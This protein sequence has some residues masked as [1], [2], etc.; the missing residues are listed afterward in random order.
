MLWLVSMW[1]AW[2][3]LAASG[4]APF[5]DFPGIDEV[6]NRIDL[7]GIALPVILIVGS[8]VVGAEAALAVLT[9]RGVNLA[10]VILM[11]LAVASTTVA[12][13][14]WLS[15]DFDIELQSTLLTVAADILVLLALSSRDAAAYCRRHEK[16]VD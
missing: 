9:F 8:V 3:R 12:F 7:T 16:T 2:P 13:V 14:Q 1:L 5:V 4:S 10:R 15:D 6:T 11:L